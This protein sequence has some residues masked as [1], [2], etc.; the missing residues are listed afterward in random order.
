[1][2]SFAGDPGPLCPP[3][4]VYLKLTYLVILEICLRFLHKLNDMFTYGINCFIE[5]NNHNKHMSR[6]QNMNGF[7]NKSTSNEAVSSI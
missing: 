2:V 6:V 4:P 1:M 7:R 3:A 5:C